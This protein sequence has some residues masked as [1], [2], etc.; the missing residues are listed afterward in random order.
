MIASALTWRATASSAGPRAAWRGTRREAARWLREMRCGSS[1]RVPPWPVGIDEVEF[2]RRRRACDGLGRQAGSA[3]RRGAMEC[4]LSRCGEWRPA[5][6]NCDSAKRGRTVRGCRSESGGALSG[7]I[8]RVVSAPDE[9]GADRRVFAP[10]RAAALGGMPRR[11]SMAAQA[12]RGR[13]CRGAGL[14]LRRS[15]SPRRAEF[16]R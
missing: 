11:S 6:Q 7:G 13:G 4:P 1:G 3:E 2:R 8:C 16:R 10:P 12:A 9:T 15:S 14:R 5:L